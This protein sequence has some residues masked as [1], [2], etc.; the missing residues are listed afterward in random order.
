MVGEVAGD[1]GTPRRRNRVH[2]LKEKKG[3]VAF[4]PHIEATAEEMDGGNEATVEIVNSGE[5]GRRSEEEEQGRSTAR[6]RGR[7]PGARRA[8]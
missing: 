8:R 4:L 6:R 2:G 3:A 1:D 5:L 7:R